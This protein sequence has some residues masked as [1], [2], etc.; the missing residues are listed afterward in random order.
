MDK[1]CAY[2]NVTIKLNGSRFK[3]ESK[4]E[5]ITV[6]VTERP[7][8]NKVNIEIIKNLERLLRK[9]VKITKGAKSRKKTIKIEGITEEVARQ[10][11]GI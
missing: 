10:T 1:Q 9:N 2:L 3:I 7:K 5:K 11:L 4:D 8:D 6:S